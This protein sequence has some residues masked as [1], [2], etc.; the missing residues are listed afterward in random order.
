MTLH[1]TNEVTVGVGVRTSMSYLIWHDLNRK[2]STLRR[3]RPPEIKLIDFHFADRKLNPLRV[4][5]DNGFQLSMTRVQFSAILQW[6]FLISFQCP[7]Y[8]FF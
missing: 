5:P 8:I 7:T 6:I 2:L 4:V 3:R 1:E